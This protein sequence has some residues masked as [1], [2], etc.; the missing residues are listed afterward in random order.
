LTAYVGA[1]AVARRRTLTPLSALSR[2][3][4]YARTA[5]STGWS[6]WL[7][8][9]AWTRWKAALFLG[10]HPERPVAILDNKR[11]KRN[12]RAIRPSMVYALVLMTLGEVNVRSPA[13]VLKRG[14]RQVQE[15]AA[16]LLDCRLD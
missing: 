8:G 9:G 16:V 12:A 5:L 15:A 14:A 6:G 4:A 2:D 3:R 10:A 11:S 7:P 13:R 1:K